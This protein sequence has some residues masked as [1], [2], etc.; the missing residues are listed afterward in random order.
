MAFDSSIDRNIEILLAMKPPYDTPVPRSP[1]FGRLRPR[2]ARR[3]RQA[4]V[5][6]AKSASSRALERPG[7]IM[8]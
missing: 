7:P 2:L 4:T 3:A 8:D 5:I 1:L 6:R